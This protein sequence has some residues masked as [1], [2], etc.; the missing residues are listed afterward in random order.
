MVACHAEELEGLQLGYTAVD[1]GA[2]EEKEEEDSQQMLAQGQSSTPERLVDEREKDQL[3]ENT[4]ERM[5]VQG[6]Y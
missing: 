1:W 6:T 4:L 3:K 5:N 2:G